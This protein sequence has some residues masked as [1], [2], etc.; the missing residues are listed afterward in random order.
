MGLVGGY[1]YP[2]DCVFHRDYGGDVV[3]G[4]VRSLLEEKGLTYL[5]RLSGVSILSFEWVWSGRSLSELTSIG[6]GREYQRGLI[7]VAEI[8]R[9]AVVRLYYC[10]HGVKV[11]GE[12]IFQDVQFMLLE[13]YERSEVLK[14]CGKEAVGED[15]LWE[16][17]ERYQGELQNFY[18]R[19]RVMNAYFEKRVKDLGM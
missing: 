4:D 15:E 1:K 11:R 7:G 18:M 17:L 10:Y 19:L 12:S 16:W 8:Y 3:F 6:Y 9:D 13:L 14:A 5:E 2:C